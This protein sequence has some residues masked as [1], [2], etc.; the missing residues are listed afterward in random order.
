MSLPEI[1][2][3]EPAREKEIFFY[4]K[5]KYYIK[6]KKKRIVRE[7]IVF[8]EFFLILHE[9]S[10]SENDRTYYSQVGPWKN[11]QFLTWSIK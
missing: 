9:S 4:T 7:T 10:E 5:S 2:N 11:Y 1:K 3:D 8:E 6:L